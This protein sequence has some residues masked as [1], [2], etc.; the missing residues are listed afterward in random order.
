M[1]SPDLAPYQYGVP[2]PLN[3]VLTIGWLAAGRDFAVGGV[4]AQ[5]MRA[6]EGLLWSN[7]VN[8]ARGFHLCEL[9]ASGTRI[10][11]TVDRG[12]LALGAAEIWLPSV[13]ESVV[14]AA[15]DLVFHYIAAHQYKPP[16][17]F[18][19]AVAASDR[20]PN[21]VPGVECERRLER[22]FEGPGGTE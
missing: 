11:I 14:F 10:E 21:W 5:M 6:I 18:L 1:Y 15:P 16:L 4:S 13:E 12:S 17:P 20:H 2:S 8:P 9:C 3:D 7:R 22:A 19:E